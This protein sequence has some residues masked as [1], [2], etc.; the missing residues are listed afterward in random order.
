M[1][2]HFLTKMVTPIIK[3]LPIILVFFFI[4]KTSIIE[5]VTILGLDNWEE[6]VVTLSLWFLYAYVIAATICIVN[7][8]WLRFLGYFFLYSVYAVA[9]FIGSN[10]EMRISPTLF[11]L[12][13]ETNGRESSE[14]LDAYAFCSKS[15]G[16]YVKLSIYA[17]ITVIMEFVYRRYI[18]PQIRFTRIGMGAYVISFVVIGVLCTGIYGCTRFIDYFRLNTTNGTDLLEYPADD[19]YTRLFCSLYF[20]YHS[21]DDIEKAIDASLRSADATTIIDES[22]SL[23]IIF[24]IGESYNKMHAS[25]YGYSLQ[26][27]PNLQELK[28]KGN[29]Y[30]FSDVVTPYNFTS[31]SLKNMLSCNSLM[32]SEKWY[33]YPFF[34]LLFRKAGYDVFFWD[35]QR[36]FFSD[37]NWQ[38]AVNSYLYNHKLSE[39]AYSKNNKI[40]YQYDEQLVDDFHEFYN[41]SPQS[42]SLVLFHLKGQHVGYGLRYPQT[43]KF[44]KFTPDDIHRTD[45]YLDTVKKQIIANYDNATYYN[46]YVLSQ[47]ID[48]FSNDNA[49]LVYLSD[50]G[51]EIY[52]YRDFRGRSYTGTVTPQYLKCQFDIPFMIWCSDKYMVKYPETKKSIQ[53]SVNKPFMIDNVCHLF[54]HVGRIRTKYYQSDRDVLSPQYIIKDRWIRGGESNYDQIKRQNTF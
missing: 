24:V 47:I 49:I 23:K 25:L 41:S 39:K 14:F 26:T 54:F 18:F 5:Q 51:E 9:Y 20:S 40:D 8:T 4:I 1:I 22:D 33:D 34:P 11:T 19:I 43:K 46:D 35:N 38:Y 7:K 3:E 29:L 6:L 17:S 21:S 32:D 2:R 37:T 45:D 13:F 28:E 15:I 30:V 48:L 31:M 42:N 12:L 53:E 50:H 36:D 10:F 44:V 52:D 27:T 16:V